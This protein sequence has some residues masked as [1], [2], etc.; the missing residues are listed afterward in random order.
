MYM[1]NIIVV[2]FIY[3]FIII[4]IFKIQSSIGTQFLLVLNHFCMLS[5]TEYKAYPNC[6]WLYTESER[7]RYI[8]WN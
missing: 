6:E 8:H 1:Y 7:S 5:S 4:I 3:L 2:I